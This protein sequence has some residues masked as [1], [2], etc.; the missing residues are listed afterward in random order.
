MLSLKAMEHLVKLGI[1]REVTG[2]RR[3]RIFAYVHYLGILDQ[4][5]E[6][7]PSSR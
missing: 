2:K 6:P 7:I 5:T 1:V 4:G 3:R